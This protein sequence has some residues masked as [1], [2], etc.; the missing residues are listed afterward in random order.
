[1]RRYT[2]Q[3]ERSGDWWAISV[4]GVKGVHTQARR[5][6]QVEDKAR[7]AIAGVLDIPMRSFTVNVEVTMPAGVENAVKNAI[8]R[9][10]AAEETG[11]AASL[12]LRKAAGI[13]VD[14]GLTVRDAGHLLHVS[15]QRVGQVVAQSRST[16]STER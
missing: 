5:L 15:H 12:A 11:R 6:D 3:V 7:D 9:R 1:M 14:E 2:A 13:L 8:D 16:D 10:Q 4:R